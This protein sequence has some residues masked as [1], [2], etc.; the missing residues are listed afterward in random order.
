MTSFTSAIAFSL[1]LVTALGA[2]GCVTDP[3]D[4]L[5]EIDGSLESGAVAKPTKKWHPGNYIWLGAGGPGKTLPL[6]ANQN[7]KGYEVIYYWR[8]LETK[9]GVYDF[10]EIEADLAKVQAAGKRLIIQ[11]NDRMFKGQTKCVPDYM[12]TPEY[13]G[14]QMVQIGT[15]GA[16]EKCTARRWDPAVEARR[17]ALLAALGARFDNEPMVEAVHTAESATTV[18]NLPKGVACTPQAAINAKAKCTTNPQGYTEDALVQSFEHRMEAL[19]ESFPK[20]LGWEALNWNLNKKVTQLFDLGESL[21]VGVWGPDIMVGHP[22]ETYGAY[23]D[24][25]GSMPLAMTGQFPGGL[26]GRLKAGVTP[27]QTYD[28][29]LHTLKLNHV[30]WS[31]SN[32]PLW[33]FSNKVLPLIDADHG[34]TNPACPSSIKCNTK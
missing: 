3:S 26:A 23:P 30:V 24:Y 13:G 29:A 31:P 15:N 25:A 12:L 20:T 7:I 33:Q 19:A 11:F 21:G 17:D 18:M 9:K 8:N 4:G 1:T 32:D 22:T 27:Q 14:G 10:S 2:A 16:V 34:V 28:F 6:V 5:D